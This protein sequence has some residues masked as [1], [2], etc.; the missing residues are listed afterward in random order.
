MAIFLTILSGLCWTLTYYYSIRIGFRDKVD[1]MPF[2]ALAL[3]ITWEGLYAFTGLTSN[4]SN[5]QAWINLVWVI[6]DLFL[7]YVY[8][9]FAKEEFA[10]TAPKKHFIPWS[11]FILIMSVA[12]QIVFMNGF[13]KASVDTGM[14]GNIIDV[15]LGAWYSAFIQNL[16]MSMLYIAMF[17]KRRGNKGQSLFIAINKC[18]GTFAPTILFGFIFHNNVVIVLGMFTFMLDLIYIWILCKGKRF[19]VE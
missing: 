15:R 3:N 6:F 9:K 8:F 5:I 7:L 2:I 11:I 16:V 14:L 19:F 1:A 18:I 10:K 12:L 17:I 13:G 4:L